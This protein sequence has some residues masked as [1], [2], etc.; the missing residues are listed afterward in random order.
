MWKTL[1]VTIALLIGSVSVNA[2]TQFWHGPNCQ[3]AKA[4]NDALTCMACAVYYESKSE[5]LAGKMAVAFTTINRT[6]SREFPDTVCEVIWQRGQYPWTNQ[7]RLIPSNP[8]QWW[9]SL[10]VAK[11]IIDL[12]ERIDYPEW[13]FTGNS[14]FFHAVYVNPRWGFTRTIR[15][16]DHIF[17]ALP[18]EHREPTCTTILDTLVGRC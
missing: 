16:G 7:S 12:S 6:R 11:T 8:I 1:L 18:K 15:V 2:Q 14:T 9:D 4:K 3:T 10:K 17:Y 5:P 13:D